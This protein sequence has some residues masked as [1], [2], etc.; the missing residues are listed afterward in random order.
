LAAVGQARGVR[1][2]FFHGRGGTISRGAG[3]THR[4]LKALPAGSVGGDVRITEQGE[5]IAQKYANPVTASYNLELL[6]AGVTRT[7]MR[8]R[9]GTAT[10]HP[11]EPTMDRLAAWSREAYTELLSSDGFL[12]F[13]RQATPVDVLE[14]SRIGSRPARRSG[15][16]TLADLR[17][18]PWVFSWSQAR[19]FLP[20]WYGVGSALER[21]KHEDQVAFAALSEHLITW[22]PLHYILSNAATSV[23]TAD[24]E[25]MGW[26]SDLVEESALR[27]RMGKTILTEYDRTVTL[28]E[29]IYGAPLDERRPN[30]HAM[31]QVRTP[32]LRL[33]HR[34]QVALLGE[35]RS[36]RAAGTEDAATLLSRL[37]L[38][39]NAIADGLGST[40]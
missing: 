18:I 19:F 8:E 11:L 28:L 4:F 12:R 16:A 15:Q 10:T 21:L 1:I 14:E 2:R 20:G 32:G 38:T 27:E 9:F 22:A 30:V 40:G 24:A 39:V 17:A 6:L 35:W 13:Y 33:L 31:I 3:P 5:T 29:E 34:Q 26:Y 23:A 37:L 7:T 25:V 36:K